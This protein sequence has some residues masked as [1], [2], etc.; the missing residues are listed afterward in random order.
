MDLVFIIEGTDD[1]LAAKAA[2]DATAPAVYDGLVRQTYSIDR[3]AE[4]A[5]EGTVRYGKRPHRQDGYSK[6]T[7]NCNAV[8]CNVFFFMLVS[9]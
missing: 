9:R 6:Y 7:L 2:L 8:M 5:W 3:I 1:D 4:D